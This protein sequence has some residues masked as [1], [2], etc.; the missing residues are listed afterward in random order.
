MVMPSRRQAGDLLR[1][2]E[3]SE[4]DQPSEACQDEQIPRCSGINKDGSQCR[5]TRALGDGLCSIHRGLADSAAGGRAKAARIQAEKKAAQAAVVRAR[6]A[7]R[8]RLALALAERWDAV[9]A[10]LLD[11]AIADGDRTTLIRLMSE[12]FGKPTEHV[13]QEEKT[14]ELPLE[15]LVEMWREA[16]AQRE[17]AEGT[18]VAPG[19]A[20]DG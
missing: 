12:A 19:T 5:G 17:A 3:M 14:E 15:V 2:V 20:E 7:P 18:D 16:K 10:V 6:M 4:H 8:D 9:Q 11:G 13:V 1:G